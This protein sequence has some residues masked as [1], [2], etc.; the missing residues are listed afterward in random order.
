MYKKVLNLK[1]ITRDNS[2]LLSHIKKS[3]PGGIQT[4]NLL[5]RSQMLYSV[6]LQAHLNSL[7]QT[8]AQLPASIV[9]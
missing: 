5:I 8:K 7:F 4:P 9:S 1:N 3:E 2:K 6:K